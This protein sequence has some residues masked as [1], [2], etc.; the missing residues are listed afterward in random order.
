MVARWPETLGAGPTISMRRGRANDLAH[1]GA[2]TAV[3]H[4]PIVC[5]LLHAPT[6]RLLQT[7]EGRE[8]PDFSKTHGCTPFHNQRLAE[9]SLRREGI[10]TFSRAKA[11]HQ[12]S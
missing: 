12:V 3:R 5:N 2:P 6:R 8:I 4:W 9:Q 1:R 11:Y 10:H 7:Q